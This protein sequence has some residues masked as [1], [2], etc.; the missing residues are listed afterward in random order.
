MK[1]ELAIAT[2]FIAIT[3]CQSDSSDPVDTIDLSDPVDTIDSSDPVDSTDSSDTVDSTDSS[4]T[5]DSTDSSDP[6]DTTDSSDPVDTIPVTELVLPMPDRSIGWASYK[7][8]KPVNSSDRA[9]CDR[10]ARACTS[11]FF[12]PL[13]VCPPHACAS[14]LLRLHRVP[15]PRKKTFVGEINNLA[16]VPDNRCNSGARTRMACVIVPSWPLPGTSYQV[17]ITVNKQITVSKQ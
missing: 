14:Q 3:A 13:L 17:N 1:K 11:S 10:V 16:G 2:A 6:V 7:R 9:T 12:L 8:E 4:D 5:V 15:Q